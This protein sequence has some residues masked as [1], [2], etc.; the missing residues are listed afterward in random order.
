MEEN[1]DSG[2]SKCDGEN[3][4]IIFI[5]KSDNRY[6]PHAHFP[7]NTNWYFTN[8]KPVHQQPT[9]TKLYMELTF[10]HSHVHQLEIFIIQY[11]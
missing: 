8:Y 9:A 2:A 3:R 6:G 7:Q 5:K 4:S 1:C 10:I 11:G